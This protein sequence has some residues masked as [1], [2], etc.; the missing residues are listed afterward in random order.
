MKVCISYHSPNAKELHNV[1][2]VDKL[3]THNFIAT[4]L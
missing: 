3:L 4:F 1:E 2:V